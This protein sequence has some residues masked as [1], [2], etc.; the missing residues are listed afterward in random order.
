MARSLFEAAL[1]DLVEEAQIPQQEKV[2]S[3]QEKVAEV[4]GTVAKS[5]VKLAH[6]LRES[7]Q[8]PTY[9]DLINFI[10]GK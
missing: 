6:L 5:L 1:N 8:E 3:L 10:G 7:Q 2:A 9:E 4:D